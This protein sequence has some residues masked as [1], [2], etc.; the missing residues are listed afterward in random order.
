MIGGDFLPS[1][2]LR[3]CP[4]WLPY[5]AIHSQ[6]PHLHLGIP[7]IRGDCLRDFWLLFDGFL[8]F[9]TVFEPGIPDPR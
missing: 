1:D 2:I 6:H 4:T 8:M 5:V 9:V 7:V 3:L